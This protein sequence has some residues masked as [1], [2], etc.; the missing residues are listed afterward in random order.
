[1]TEGPVLALVACAAPH[2]LRVGELIELL[3]QTA[4]PSASPPRRPPPPGSTDRHWQTGF[5]VRVEWRT[6]GEPEPHPPAT[7]VAV[8]PATF[9][10]INK[11]AQ[12]I[13]DA[14]ALGILNEAL[15]AGIPVYAF[16]NVKEQLAA[17]PATTGTYGYWRTRPSP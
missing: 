15:G 9:N 3:Q 17:H 2:V 12:G 14:P 5:P 7:A 6:P 11:W 16:P 4:G 8:L 1:M 10:V 13:N